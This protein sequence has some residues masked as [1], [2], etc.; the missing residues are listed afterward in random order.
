MNVLGAMLCAMRSMGDYR[1][2]RIEDE[3]LRRKTVQLLREYV[4][5]ERPLL[6]CLAVEVSIHFKNQTNNLKKRKAIQKSTTLLN[7]NNALF[8]NNNKSLI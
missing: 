7:N 6:K 5:S 8:D 2:S 1:H 3:D 4:C